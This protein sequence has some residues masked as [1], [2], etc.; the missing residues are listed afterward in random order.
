VL[1][2]LLIIFWL[3]CDAHLNTFVDVCC[4]VFSEGGGAF[5]KIRGGARP[6]ED[7]ATQHSKLTL[8]NKFDAL[9]T[10]NS[11]LLTL[12]YSI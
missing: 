3:S 7:P 8:D 1:T 4:G 6:I 5:E 10:E 9:D 11:W 2:H 12:A